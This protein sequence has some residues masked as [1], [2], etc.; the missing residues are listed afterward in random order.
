M[1]VIGAAA[2]EA[3]L[4]FEACQAG[5]RQ[6]GGDLLDFGHDFGADPVAGQEQELVGGHQR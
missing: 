6:R 1:R 3:A 5:A 2:D 4:E